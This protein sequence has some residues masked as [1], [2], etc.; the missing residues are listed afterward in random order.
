MIICDIF[1]TMPF[2]VH[3][4]RRFAVFAMVRYSYP[5]KQNQNS[6]LV[7]RQNDNTS[8]GGTLPWLSNCK[9]NVL[10]VAYSL[11]GIKLDRGNK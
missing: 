6:L 3:Q 5:Q 7:K 9:A 10:Y 1:V 2:L 11:V 8:P 4:L